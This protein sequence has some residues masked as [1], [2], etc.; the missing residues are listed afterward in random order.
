MVCVQGGHTP[1]LDSD[2]GGRPT[3]CGI[4]TP[5]ALRA[6]SGGT[7]G[8]FENRRISTKFEKLDRLRY[9]GTYFRFRTGFGALTAL[10]LI[11][12][13]YNRCRVVTD[14]Y[15]PYLAVCGYSSAGSVPVQS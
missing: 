8:K 12:T 1:T 5:P 4:K 10:Q 11:I 13:G 7:G 9:S 14:G 3:A 6:G 15:Y 2:K